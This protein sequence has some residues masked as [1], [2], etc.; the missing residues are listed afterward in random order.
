[1]SMNL[2]KII[3]VL[4][5]ISVLSIIVLFFIV[6]NSKDTRI[7]PVEIIK[8]KD[9]SSVNIG[10]SR[11]EIEK[12]IGKE[13]SS[14]QSADL[15]ISKYKSDNIYR[16]HQIYFK[17]NNSELIIKEITDSSMTTDKMRKESGLAT[18]ILYEKREYSSFNLY[19]YPSKGIAYKGH[20]NE[21]LILEIW[22]FKP[23]DIKNFINRY[24]KNYQE[25]PYLIQNSY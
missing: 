6:K 22:Y 3:N 2:K 4:V 18:N 15:I 21:G 1:M 17:N 13:I 5:I 19:V 14:T 25:E 10:S 16:P 23:T 11:E 24:A 7:K 9:I 20:A 8:Y 12:E